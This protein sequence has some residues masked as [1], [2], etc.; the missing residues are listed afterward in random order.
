MSKLVAKVVEIQ[1][2]D[3]I[4]IV[5][6]ALGDELLTM[7]SLELSQR[8]LVGSDVNLVINSTHVAIAK[9]LSGILSYSNQLNAKILTLNSGK[10]LT[11]VSL[12]ISGVRVESIITKA[13]SVKMDLK[14]GDEVIAL[15]KASE[16]SIAEILDD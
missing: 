8:L 12:E 6:F 1:K 15:V 4:S 9:E 16:L 13:S 2:H 14:V 7:M 3:G 11:Q 5:S 10:L